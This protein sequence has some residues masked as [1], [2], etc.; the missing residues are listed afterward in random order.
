MRVLTRVRGQQQP[1]A[2]TVPESVGTCSSRSTNVLR[3]GNQSEAAGATRDRHRVGAGDQR[4][5]TTTTTAGLCPVGLCSLRCF[6]C[7]VSVS[8]ERCSPWIQ[9]LP[10]CFLLGARA[11]VFLPQLAALGHSA[12]KP[13][14]ALVRPNARWVSFEKAA[15][16]WRADSS[17]HVDAFA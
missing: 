17:W 13:P 16:P 15:H 10:A 14:S 12:A 8:A 11:E 1:G 3:Q 2:L 5:C 9:A 4:I 7:S 6:R